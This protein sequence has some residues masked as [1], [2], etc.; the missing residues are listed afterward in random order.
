MILIDHRKD[1]ALLAHH[2]KPY[3]I[4]IVRAGGEGSTF[5]ELEYG[6]IVFSGHGAD[7]IAHIGCERKALSDLVSS[8]DSRRLSGSQLIGLLDSYDYIYLVVEGEWR[9]GEAGELE[10]RKSVK[11]KW[12]WYGLEARGR[13]GRNGT[14][15]TMLYREV[16]NY[17][18]TLT[19][20]C[21]VNV[22]RT[23]DHRETAAWA[24]GTYRWFQKQWD[25]HRS[26][27]EIYAPIVAPQRHK[28]QIRRA[29]PI[30]ICAGNLP[31]VDRLAWKFKEVF[32]NP[33]EIANASVSELMKVEG[34]GRKGAEKIWKWWRGIS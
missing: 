5:P 24:A 27:E 30:E 28:V 21:G 13:R 4:Q 19:L 8:I 12:G 29:G 25:E 6:D 18:Q 3:G 10:V 22:V 33:H 9:A 15:P 23:R 17:L 32:K 7:G 14:T 16:S 20:K 31:G 34:V 26:H 11:G 1:Y 2:F